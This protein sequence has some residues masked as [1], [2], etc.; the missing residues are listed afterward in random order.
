MRPQPSGTIINHQEPSASPASGTSPGSVPDSENASLSPF[1]ARNPDQK[2][3]AAVVDLL[4]R[5]PKLHALYCGITNRSIRLL[6]HQEASWVAWINRGFAEDDLRVVAKAILNGIKNGTRNPGAL[7][8]HNLIG[9]L[10]GF[11]DDLAQVHAMR[12]KP[13]M[14][15]NRAAVLRPTGRSGEP[16]S[17]DAVPVAVVLAGLRKAVGL[18]PS[19][20]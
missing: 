14:N 16:P 19:P 9:D 11:Q 2:P 10:D 13:P 4:S 20:Q 18:P 12:P 1:E 8:F 15:A 3:Q 7:K 6:A 17:K 5:I